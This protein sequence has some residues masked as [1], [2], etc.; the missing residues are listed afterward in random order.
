MSR[1]KSRKGSKNAAGGGLSKAVK[2]GKKI[3]GKGGT[4]GAP[5]RAKSVEHWAKKV[6]IAKLKNKF[7]K[8]K[9]GN[10]R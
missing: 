5:R 8:V 2:T 10:V 9:Y 3:L 7:F 4:E 1:T 6:I